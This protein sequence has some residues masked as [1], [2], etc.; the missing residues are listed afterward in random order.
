MTG[1]EE[2]NRILRLAGTVSVHALLLCAWE[3]RS[4]RLVRWPPFL[5]VGLDYPLPMK[6][7]PTSFDELV[8]V[9]ARPISSVTSPRF[10]RCY[11][12]ECARR[13]IGDVRSAFQT[14]N[15]VS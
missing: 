10:W 9:S 4:H 5:F 11:L 1:D 2:E 15:S 12:T 13:P 7:F 6:A 3:N 8:E 14:L